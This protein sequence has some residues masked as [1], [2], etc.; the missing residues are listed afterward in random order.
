MLSLKGGSFWYAGINGHLLLEWAPFNWSGFQNVSTAQALFLCWPYSPSLSLTSRIPVPDLPLTS[1]V[2]EWGRYPYFPFIYPSP[3]I[4]VL[5]QHGFQR[6][7]DVAMCNQTADTSEFKRGQFPLLTPLHLYK[8]TL[9]PTGQRKIW[10]CLQAGSS[11]REDFTLTT[12][13]MGYL[14]RPPM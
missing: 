12:H 3:F 11:V 5:C 2:P 4:I 7:P 9:P 10:P 13:F 14:H 6:S 1:G 8:D